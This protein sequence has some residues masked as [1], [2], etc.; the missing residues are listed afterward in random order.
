MTDSELKSDL[1][2]AIDAVMKLPAANQAEIA[3]FLREYVEEQRA[4]S[5]LTK[6]QR[7]EVLRRL[8]DPNPVYYTQEEVFDEI[9][10]L[11]SEK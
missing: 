10:K 9:E 1:E 8:A 7:A 3:R 5:L 4:P 6:E 2:A 11:L